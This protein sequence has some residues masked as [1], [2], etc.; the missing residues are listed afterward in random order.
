M[1]DSKVERFVSTWGAERA[2]MSLEGRG[3]RRGEAAR[4]RV[5]FAHGGRRARAHRA[6]APPTWNKKKSSLV[7]NIYIYIYNKR[8]A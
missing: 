4:R 8:F 1:R 7:F 2:W 6:R 5:L 3:R